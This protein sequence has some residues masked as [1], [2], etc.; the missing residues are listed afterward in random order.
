[1]PNFGWT[2]VVPIALYLGLA[3]LPT[4]RPAFVGLVTAALAAIAVSAAGIQF[5]STGVVAAIGLLS[6]SVVAL[7]SM[8]QL[9]RR[10][11]GAGRSPW[12]YP[13]LVG[14]G[15]VAGVV[16]AAQIMAE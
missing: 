6:G 3:A 1:M 15:L 12:V 4:G 7:A 10:G 8:I 2:L 14:T 16:L 11:L 5:E 13:A 9:L